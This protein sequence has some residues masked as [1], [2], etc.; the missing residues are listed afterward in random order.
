[1]TVKLSSV[2]IKDETSD[3]LD[4]SM[5]VKAGISNLLAASVR[6]KDETPDLLLSSIKETKQLLNKLLL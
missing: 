2:K 1:L 4:G 6:V 5:T 3:L